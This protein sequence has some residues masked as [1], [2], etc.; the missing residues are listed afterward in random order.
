MPIMSVIERA[1]YFH[2]R[3]SWPDARARIS[4]V[5]GPFQIFRNVNIIGRTYA[6]GLVKDKQGK[7]NATFGRR[8]IIFSIVDLAEKHRS[9]QRHW[10]IIRQASDA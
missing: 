5:Q 10:S 3:C 2:A 8:V 1:S 9:S 4:N 6:K 7:W